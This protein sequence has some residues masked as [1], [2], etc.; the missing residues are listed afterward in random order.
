MMIRAMLP[1]E[2]TCATLPTEP[3]LALVVLDKRLLSSLI[4]TIRTHFTIPSLKRV[5]N[6][7]GQTLLLLCKCAQV[8]VRESLLGYLRAHVTHV[9]PD[10]LLEVQVPS[11]LPRTIAQ[12][13]SS[14]W[15]VSFHPNRALEDL[16]HGRTFSDAE[17]SGVIER[18]RLLV[19]KTEAGGY[20]NSAM[21]M[22]P[23]S[24]ELGTSSNTGHILGHATM[25]VIA[26]V[27]NLQL[28]NSTV[29]QCS[30]ELADGQSCKRRRQEEPGGGKQS[31]DTGLGNQSG[32]YLCTGMDVY[33][34]TEPCV[35][36]TMA[37]VH[38]RISRIFFGSFRKD[39]GGIGE[40][41]LQ[42][43]SALNHNFQAFQVYIDENG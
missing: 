17:K 39:F 5:V 8:T 4:K 34:A 20:A 29:S 42:D 26:K 3:A 12:R 32:D 21:V 11:R 13:D 23:H 35:M 2:T 37:L 28:T 36:C 7:D 9:S 16:V 30:P 19:N 1:E 40:A 31:G 18:I 10:D 14:P 22:S 27:A 43:V 15:P 41:K 25:E 24:G 6:R 38:S 33:L